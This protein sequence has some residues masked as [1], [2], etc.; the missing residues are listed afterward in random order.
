ML[1]LRRSPSLGY[2]GRSASD[3]EGASAD[4]FLLE[5]ARLGERGMSWARAIGLTLFLL[6]VIFHVRTGVRPV[7]AL[8]VAGPML[9]LGILW[10]VTILWLT[11]AN[12]INRR[13][14]VAS[15]GF[16]GII[17]TISLVPSV[18]WPRPDFNGFATQPTSAALLLALATVPL[19]LSKQ[20]ARLE[21][22][23]VLVGG[24]GLVWLD[25]TFNGARASSPVDFV[26]ATALMAST[27]VVAALMSDW[28][29]RTVYRGM[30]ATRNAERAKNRLGAY[31]SPEFAREVLNREMMS[32]HRAEY[33]AAVLFTDL[34]GFTSRGESTSPEDLFREL[35][36]YFEVMVDVVQ[37]HGGV[38]DKFMGDALMAVFGVPSA[39][40]DCAEKAIA[41]A[42]A[43][44]R[45]LRSHN[46]ERAHFGLVP[47][48][49]GIG[50]HF[51]AV[52]AGDVGSEARRQFT[53]IG[54][55]VNVASRIEAMTK[56][57]GTSILISDHAV[58]AVKEGASIL[59]W[60]RTVGNVEVRGRRG[61][62]AL[63]SGSE[64]GK[65]GP[66]SPDADHGSLPSSST[67]DSLA[68]G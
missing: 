9:V 33:R 57:L 25:Q 13:W 46:I 31:I 21:V 23:I 7:Q 6:M 36:D 63:W 42:F 16:D 27:A 30:D 53:V 15:A 38:V 50:I 58:N 47:L 48:R 4:A 24:I 5:A 60:M 3:S 68:A 11:R 65:F 64:R 59:A 40:P 28:I 12:T 34:R 44:D 61:H 51:G 19:R 55:T 41:A 10:S 2:G 22:G 8:Y 20:A 67:A 35:N 62:I 14:L 37:R 32:G 29:R 56:K 18:I 1:R 54:D 45:A 39:D 26:T 43:M 66:A 17:A 52:V 49:H